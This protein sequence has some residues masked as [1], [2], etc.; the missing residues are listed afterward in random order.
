MVGYKPDFIFGFAVNGLLTVV[1]VVILL[2]GHKVSYLTRISGGFIVIAGLMLVL[3]RA[4]N[5]LDPDTGFAVCISILVVFGA[6][7]GIV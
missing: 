1:Q 2:Y 7:G 4:A 6:M 5:N 3:P